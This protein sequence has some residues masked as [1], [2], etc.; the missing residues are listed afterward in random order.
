[1]AQSSTTLR[2]RKTNAK[3]LANELILTGRNIT[4]QEAL[5]IGLVNRI[6]QNVQFDRFDNTNSLD[7][8]ICP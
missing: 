1:M 3:G 5:D 6:F 7:P 4:A 8:P 2:N